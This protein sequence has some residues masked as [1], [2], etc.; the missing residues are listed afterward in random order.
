MLVVII[1]PVM[2]DPFIRKSVQISTIPSF[3]LHH[4]TMLLDMQEFLIQSLLIHSQH[5]EINRFV[6]KSQVVLWKITSEVHLIKQK[7]TKQN[8]LLKVFLVSMSIYKYQIVKQ[9]MQNI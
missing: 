4:D 3:D 7:A 9:V 5:M 2:E 1:I 8:V 6:V